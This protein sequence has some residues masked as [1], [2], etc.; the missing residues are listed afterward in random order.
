M[1]GGCG[2]GLMTTRHNPT[3][4]LGAQTED[5]AK[6]TMIYQKSMSSINEEKGFK[7]TVFGYQ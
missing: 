3:S 7:E 5:E 1:G 6:D 4:R 2:A